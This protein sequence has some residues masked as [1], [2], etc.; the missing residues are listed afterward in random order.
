MRIMTTQA[1]LETFREIIKIIQ[2]FLLWTLAEIPAEK[3]IYSF[4]IFGLVVVTWIV[5]GNLKKSIENSQKAEGKKVIN[6]VNNCG[7]ESE[8]IRE[9]VV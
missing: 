9:K 8:K 4:A 3:Q 1:D 7:S 2:L 6:L 5:S